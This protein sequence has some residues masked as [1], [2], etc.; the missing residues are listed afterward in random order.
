MPSA[1]DDTGCCQGRA[2]R[3]KFYGKLLDILRVCLHFSAE[4]LDYYYCSQQ[5]VI[6]VFENAPFIT[7]FTICLF[8]LKK[9]WVKKFCIYPLEVQ[10]VKV[11]SVKRHV[12]SN[13]FVL[14]SSCLL[15]RNKNYG[16][17]CT[18]SLEVP[19]YYLL[20]YIL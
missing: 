2:A 9:Y 20:L 4:K 3:T 7:L 16:S 1:A 8:Y 17:K 10:K 6:S 15:L 5:Q 18:F 11:F 19:Q 13:Y 14:T 12:I